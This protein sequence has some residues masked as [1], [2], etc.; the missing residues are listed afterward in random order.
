MEVFRNG[1]DD[2]KCEASLHTVLSHLAHPTEDAHSGQTL[3]ISR[4]A[5]QTNV[6]VSK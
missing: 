2:K 4:H 3:F 5:V 1:C 6:D